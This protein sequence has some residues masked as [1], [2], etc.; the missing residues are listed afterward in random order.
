MIFVGEI[1]KYERGK[2]GHMM[3]MYSFKVNLYLLLTV[4]LA[5]KNVYIYVDLYPFWYFPQ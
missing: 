3:L 4:V 2:S 1:N 5:R